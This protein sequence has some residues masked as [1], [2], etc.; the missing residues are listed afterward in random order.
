MS[1]AQCVVCGWL[2]EGTLRGCGTG[3]L[4]VRKRLFRI[5]KE[6]FLRCGIGFSGWRNGLYGMAERCLRSLRNVRMACR[7][8]VYGGMEGVFAMSGI[9][10][11]GRLAG[12]LRRCVN[13]KMLKCILLRRMSKSA[14]RP[15]LAVVCQPCMVTAS[16]SLLV[17]PVSEQ[18]EV[19]FQR[20]VGKHLQ[21]SLRQTACRTHRRCTAPEESQPL[22][23]LHHV[24]V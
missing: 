11:A 18:C 21:H 20:V 14:S 7:N 17:H 9:C 2:S 16:V 12:F 5:A 1:V 13:I 23:L 4:V 10:G 6:A 8:G 24:R 15:P 3:F 19:A 22:R